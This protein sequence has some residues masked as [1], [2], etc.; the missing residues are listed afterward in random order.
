MCPAEGL[1]P[2]PFGVQDS[3]PTNGASWPGPGYFLNYLHSICLPCGRVSSRKKHSLC[4]L[5]PCVPSAQHSAWP[6]QVLVKHWWQ[7]VWA[8]HLCFT[9]APSLL[10]LGVLL[11]VSACGPARLLHYCLFFVG[12]VEFLSALECMWQEMTVVGRSRAGEHRCRGRRGMPAYRA[13][14]DC[15]DVFQSPTSWKENVNTEQFLSKK[16]KCK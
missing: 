15:G 11:K 13:P 2:Q 10:S 8:W 3:A 9:S 14:H 7:L 16:I 6:Q 5:H 4:L 12:Y 1:N